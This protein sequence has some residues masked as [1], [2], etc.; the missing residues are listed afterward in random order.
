VAPATGHLTRASSGLRAAR[1][2]VPSALLFRVRHC[3]AEAQSRWAARRSINRAPKTFFL[4]KIGRCA[5]S[6][7]H[8]AC[9]PLNLV[10]S[11]QLPVN[12]TLLFHEEK[13]M[14][15]R[16][17]TSTVVF[18]I[19]VTAMLCVASCTTTRS[20]ENV[21]LETA[22]AI[23]GVTSEQVTISNL[24]IGMSSTFPLSVPS[25]TANWEAETPKGHYQCESD[26][27]LKRRA[28]CVKQ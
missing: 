22:R 25:E 20:D 14:F 21:R 8:V 10:A 19:L 6:S 5:I 4:S 26:D 3:A 28:N 24:H 7:T 1:C 11:S 2:R 27:M 18:A 16:K 13:P 12:R 9:P 17:S 23:G 15:A